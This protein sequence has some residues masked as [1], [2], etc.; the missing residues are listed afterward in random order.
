[1]LRIVTPKPLKNALKNGIIKKA[2]NQKGRTV[3]T[4]CARNLNSFLIL[5]IFISCNQMEEKKKEYSNAAY[6]NEHSG[7]E[8]YEVIEIIPNGYEVVNINDY[9]SSIPTVFFDKKTTSIFIKGEKEISAETSN[10]KFLKLNKC[11]SIID[12]GKAN[13]ILRDGTMKGY[14]YYSNWI[15]NGD[16]N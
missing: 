5:L 6:L 11:G 8:K 3:R 13:R 7:T 4:S 1:M 16:T 12:A 14:D 10:Y 9:L 2:D 15:I